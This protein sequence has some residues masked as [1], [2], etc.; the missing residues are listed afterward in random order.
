MAFNEGR[1]QTTMGKVVTQTG[2]VAGK[3]APA[4][5][6]LGVATGQ[7]EIAAA[8]V[9]L[10]AASPLLVSGG[11]VQKNYGRTLKGASKGKDVSKPGKKTVTGAFQLGK[12]VAIASA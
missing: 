7:P 12:D 8:G 2:K 6:L 9:G 4:V 3:V 10:A 5:T 1:L 11:R